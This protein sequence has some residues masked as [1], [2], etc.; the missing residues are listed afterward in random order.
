[1]DL[2]PVPSKFGNQL[3]RGTAPRAAMRRTSP[4]MTNQIHRN[5]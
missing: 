2:Q 4:E 1:M 5:H 3:I